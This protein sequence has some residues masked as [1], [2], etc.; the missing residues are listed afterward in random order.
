[1]LSH[2]AE[3]VIPRLGLESGGRNGL[4]AIDRSYFDRVIVGLEE[5]VS[6]AG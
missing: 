4:I 1:M 3:R 6:V 2:T 5:L